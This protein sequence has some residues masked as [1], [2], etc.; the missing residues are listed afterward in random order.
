MAST[1]P[2]LEALRLEKS[3]VEARLKEPMLSE[4]TV[5]Q[6]IRKNNELH[7]LIQDEEMKASK[8][9]V[10]SLNETTEL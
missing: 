4:D 2:K 10:R 3:Q 6:L 5:R 8:P 7:A 9:F 1:N